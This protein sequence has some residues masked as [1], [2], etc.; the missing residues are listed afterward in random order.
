MNSIILFVVEDKKV[1]QDLLVESCNDQAWLDVE[2]RAT[3]ENAGE[4]IASV[5][6]DV[7]SVDLMFGDTFLGFWYIQKARTIIPS[8]GLV[9][10]SD[11]PGQKE[12]AAAREID[13]FITKK[14]IRTDPLLYVR[15]IKRSARR[16]IFSSVGNCLRSLSDMDEE[17]GARITQIVAN[18]DAAFC[19]R[20][21]DGMMAKSIPKGIEENLCDLKDN[22]LKAPCVEADIPFLVKTFLLQSNVTRK[23][24]ASLPSECK[25]D[26]Q[27]SFRIE[28]SGSFE[29]VPPA[30][31]AFLTLKSDSVGLDVVVHGDGFHIADD[32]FPI[33]LS[34]DDSGTTLDIPVVVKKAGKLQIVAEFYASG[35]RVGYVRAET[36]ATEG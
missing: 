24:H 35:T 22:I 36:N 9:I 21:L 3:T 8:I 7:V 28:I 31:G 4:E 14:Q 15:A 6:P 20:E 17:A 2:V 12:R 10:V 19:I 25:I 30:S 29:S 33:Q 13:S 18:E 32:C 34:A 23:L 11:Y 16:K 5:K 26:Q 27:I 1:D